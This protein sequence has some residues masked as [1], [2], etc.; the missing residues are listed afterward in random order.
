M[1]P[2]TI[3]AGGEDLMTPLGRFNHVLLIGEIT[4][5]PLYGSWF[6]G[7]DDGRRRSSAEGCSYRRS[8]DGLTGEGRTHLL[9]ARC[10]EALIM[11]AADDRLGLF[12]VAARALFAADVSY[13]ERC[14]CLGFKP[15]LLTIDRRSL[16][17]LSL[18]REDR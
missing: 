7:V 4:E 13:I 9:L 18:A 12:D 3:V 1:L 6:V 5:G 17:G 8:A 14:P 10:A 2:S 11:A 16:A 15:P